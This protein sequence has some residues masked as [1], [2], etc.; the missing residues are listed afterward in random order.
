MKI[1][2][3]NYEVFNSGTVISF[4]QEPI[5]FQLAT[6]LKIRL[7]FRDEMEKKEE[8]RLEFNPISK[9][10]LEITLVNFNNSLGTGNTAPLLMGTLNNKKLYLNFRV[11]ALTVT[12]NKTIHYSWYLGEEVNNG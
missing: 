4:E 1:T 9:N 5:T 12:T 8:H 11:Y 3:G 2:S 10:E 6:D 7:A